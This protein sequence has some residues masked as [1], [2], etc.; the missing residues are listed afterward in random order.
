MSVFA[1]LLCFGLLTGCSEKAPE[2]FSIEPRIGRMGDVLTILGRG[3]GSE[4]N[5]SY[6]TIAGTPPTSSSYLSWDDSLISVRLPEFGDAGLVYVHRGSRKSNPAM[7]A[8]QFTLPEPAQGYD[9]PTISSIEP[10]S[11][12]IGSLITIRGSN[13]GSSREK[14]GVFFSWEAEF[15][16]TTGAYPPEYVEVFDEEFGYEIWSERE[17]RLRIPDGA[18]SGD[19]LVKTP[20]GNSRPVFFEITGK[21]GSKIFKDKRSYNISYKAGIQINRAAFPNALYL[22]MPEPVLSAAQRNVRLLYRSIEPMVENYRG[23]SIFQ[24]IDTQ[25]G[26]GLNIESSY[27]AEVFAV[28]TS[29]RT[30]TPARSGRP[31]QLTSVYTLPSA[32]IPTGDSGLR[33]QSSAIIG[34][35][36]LPYVKAQKIYDWLVS[37]VPFQEAPLSGGALDALEENKAD[38]YRGALLFCA[39]ARAAGVPALPVAGVLADSRMNA[40]KHYWAEF[41]LDGFG[42]IPVDPALGAGAAPRD[43][44][45]RED[46]GRNYFGNLDHRRVA[47]SRGEH[48]LNQMTPRG[49]TVQRRDYSLQ[50]LWEEAVGI[51]SYSSLWSDVTITETHIQ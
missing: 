40:V 19:L 51:E 43:F 5:E 23:T 35:E 12:A 21:P 3:F 11:G 36:Q 9:T 17:I 47:F 20:R 32:L 46:H 18:V 8:N 44:T 41:W 33:T 50:N 4:R 1:F 28:E 15:S 34:R 16:P 22:W 49:R 39:L 29:V 25:P 42:W 24:F 26:T 2:I 31:S 45:L 37:K 7:F 10:A 27:T 14:S 30:M 48:F 6:I 13:F 38:S